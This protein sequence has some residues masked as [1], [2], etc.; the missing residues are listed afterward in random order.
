MFSKENK[1]PE[2]NSTDKPKEC[3]KASEAPL[4]GLVPIPSLVIDTVRIDFHQEV[5]SAASFRDGL[6]DGKGAT[7]E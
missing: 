3:M 2:P 4:I 1:I 6:E 5:D 7:Q